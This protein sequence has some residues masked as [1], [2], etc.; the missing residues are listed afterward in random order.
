[1]ADVPADDAEPPPAWTPDDPLARGCGPTA[2]HRY[3]CSVARYERIAAAI[4]DRILAGEYAPGERLPGQRALATAWKTT[5]PTVR[6]A[7]DQLQRDGLLRVEHGVGT[8]VADLDR[9][10]DPFMV[11]SFTETL[12]ERGLEVETRLLD[13]DPHAQSPAAAAA[14]DAPAGAGLVCLSRLRL[15]GGRGIVYQRSYLAG[16][17]RARLRRYDG[18]APLYTFLRDRLGLVA[19]AYRETLTADGTP[20]DVAEALH[21]AAGAPVLVSRRTTAT[22]DG[23]PF[24]FDEAYLPPDRV[25]VVVSRQGT[26]CVTDLVPVFATPP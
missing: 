20:R 24:L 3:G 5:L 15:V 17:Y 22:A 2:A 13:V 11:A 1:M 19:A 21:C 25:Q 26:R 18:A 7:L 16:R 14:L 10:Y 6:Q 4:R 9:S 12:R 8:F 23:R